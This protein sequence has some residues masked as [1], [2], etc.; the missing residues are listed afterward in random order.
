MK[1][2]KR[3]RYVDLMF[4]DREHKVNCEYFVEK[5][6]NRAGDRE[7]KTLIYILTSLDKFRCDFSKYYDAERKVISDLDEL[8]A[9]PLVA[10]SDSEFAL[11]R[12]AYHLFTSN[13][14]DINFVNTFDCLDKTFSK[15]AICA[16][17]YR[18][19]LEGGF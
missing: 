10:F 12:L 14:Y 15:L 19:K 16:I 11:L 5:F 17:K 1:G 18:F 4:V 13:D 9:D 7:A 8:L 2:A 6:C 3:M